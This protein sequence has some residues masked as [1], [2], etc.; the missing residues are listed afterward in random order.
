MTMRNSEYWASRD[1]EDKYS[2][3]AVL[4]IIYSL[5]E[6][7]YRDTQ[8]L[9]YAFY[10]EYSEDNNITYEEATRLLTPIE[11]KE[12]T[13][14]IKRLKSSLNS[15]DDSP[16]GNATRASIEREIRLLQGRGRI[17]RLQSLCDSINE[18]WIDVS[19]Q[20]D[21]TLGELLRE[22]HAREYHQS[23]L[24]AGVAKTVIPMKQIE[25]AIL[26]PTFGNS[27]SD[28]VWRNKNN[29]VAFI[30]T[31]ITKGLV[32]GR[33]IRKT[34]KLLLAQQG[35]A[36]YQA[37]RLV[38]TENCAARTAGTLRGYKDSK[39]VKYVEIL[40]AGDERMCPGCGSKAGEVIPLNKAIIGDNI[41]PFH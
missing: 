15:L 23:L 27:F 29:I 9:I 14:R 35:V 18:K 4:T 41:P 25:A 3:D 31:E 32:T 20:I 22:T 19:M 24:E 39:T 21:K 37:A 33:D 38:R 11:L 2:E 6:E 7:G 17:T 1:I 5:L 10:G 16:L 40:V 30:N 12:C 36:K 28:N 34:A 26:I 8:Q 13:N